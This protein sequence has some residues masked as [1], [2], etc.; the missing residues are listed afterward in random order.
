MDNLPEL[1]DIQLPLGVSF[2]P[3]AYGWWVILFCVILLIFLCEIIKIYRKKNKKLY[4]L[5]LLGHTNSNNLI[6]SAI[7]VSEILRRICVYKYPQA[8]SL[9]GN[10]WIDFLNKKTK[11]TATENTA[12]L[13]VNAPYLNKENHKYT[14]NDLDDLIEFSKGWIGENL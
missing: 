13:L 10:E 2:F 9:Y 14:K 4:A 11:Q 3:P 5:K 1:K 7:S 8:N 6:A 12:E